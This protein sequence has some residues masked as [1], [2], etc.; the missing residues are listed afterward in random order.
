MPKAKRKSSTQ[1][2]RKFFDTSLQVRQTARNG[3]VI[4]L[5][6]DNKVYSSVLNDVITKSLGHP[7]HC[8]PS[9]ASAREFIDEHGAERVRCLLVDLKLKEPPHGDV[10]IAWFLEHYPDIPIV[11]HTAA[12]DRE[13]EAIQKRFCNVC[14]VG[15][16]RPLSVLVEAL[17]LRLNGDPAE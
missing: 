16:N 11:V 7:T 13:I 2:L 1:L 6:E 3:N 15:K 5:V 14:V 17:G 9:V 12:P 4:L 10:L 8:V